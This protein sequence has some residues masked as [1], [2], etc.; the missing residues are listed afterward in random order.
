MLKKEGWDSCEDQTE[1]V[2]KIATHTKKT[3]IH[4]AFDLSLL[5]AVSLSS[6]LLLLF[7]LGSLLFAVMFYQFSFFFCQRMLYVVL[8]GYFLL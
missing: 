8:V 1:K 6:L 2:N 7:L 5:N 4:P 3:Q